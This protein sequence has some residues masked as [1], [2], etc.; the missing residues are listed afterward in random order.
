MTATSFRQTD[1]LSAST[2]RVSK[3]QVALFFWFFFFYDCKNRLCWSHFSSPYVYGKR[4]EDLISP[5][6]TLPTFCADKNTPCWGTRGNAP[7]AGR[8]QLWLSDVPSL[9]AVKAL[10]QQVILT[11]GLSWKTQ[12]NYC[13]HGNHNFIIKWIDGRN[14][15][16]VWSE[17]T[18]A[19]TM[20]WLIER[21]QVCQVSGAAFVITSSKTFARNLVSVLYTEA[22]NQWRPSVFHCLNKKLC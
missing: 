22:V 10:N 16:F 18:A 19:H 5:V 13:L 7:R 15:S 4:S 21:T 11:P 1:V 2:R 14:L 8:R 3:S 6:M 12:Y 17:W 20:C 9:S